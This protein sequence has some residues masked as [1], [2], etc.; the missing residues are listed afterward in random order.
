MLIGG[1]TVN[2]LQR[3]MTFRE[4]LG[5]RDYF[6]R[7]GRIGP[8]RKYD[9]APALVAHTISA[10]NG[11]KTRYSDFLPTFIVEKPVTIDDLGILLG[12]V[13]NG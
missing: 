10:V 1:A 6:G 4:W 7:V 3:R 5:W 8:N 11:G 2:E 9:R 13:T 12:A